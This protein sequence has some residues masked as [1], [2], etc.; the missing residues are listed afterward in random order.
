MGRARQRR[1]RLTPLDDAAAFGERLRRARHAAG[2][3]LRELAF[4]G[5]TAPYI[6]R[7]EHGDRTPSLQMLRALAERLGVTPEYLATGEE[8][9]NLDA[10]LVEAE[11][12][13][14]LGDL[15]MAEGGFERVARAATGEQRARALGGL[16]ELASRRGDADEA[17]ASLEEARTLLGPRFREHAALVEALGRARALRSEFAEAVALFD[18][19]RTAAS[20]RGDQPTTL[21]FTVLLA[22][23][24]ID[25]GDLRGSADALAA[26]LRGA[27]ELGDPL[28]RARVDWSQSRLH[29]VEGRH[30]LAARFAERA[31][32]QLQVAEDDLYAARAHHLLAY[33]EVERGDP[34][35]ALAWL[36]RGLPQIERLG[37][38]YEIAL[39]RLEQ[40]RAHLA[41]GQVAVAKHYATEAAPALT[42]SGRG[43]VGRCFTVLGDVWAAADEPEKA[44]DMYD[45][46]IAALEDHRNPHLARAYGQKA[47]LLEALGR[48]DEALALLKRAVA[49]G[50]AGARVQRGD[51]G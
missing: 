39:F 22:N 48:K 4:P 36:E 43:D 16:A 18:A 30:D 1:V 44:L 34:A 47:T 14:R 15:E 25:L 37:D 32:A 3:S 2:M 10:L 5:C 40:A 11:L 8:A 31:L 27:E 13:L 19:A 20:E 7:L 35:R 21:R 41:L 9:P 38:A 46:A 50:E 24:Y 49:L 26:A 12:A 29:T 23:A 6:S 42:A 33:I 51:S 45:A 17:I 28:L